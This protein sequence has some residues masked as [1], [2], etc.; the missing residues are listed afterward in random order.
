IRRNPA[1]TLG[2]AAIVQTIYGI[3]GAFIAWGELGAANRLQT[4]L[5]LQPNSAQAAG[6]ALGQFFASFLPYLFLTFGLIFVFEAV[7]TGML[8][9]ALGRGLLGDKITMGEAW[10]LARVGPVLGVT[11]LVALIVLGIYLPVALIVVAL[12]AAHLVG[13][14]IFI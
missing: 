5:N 9:G 10:R 1:A 3:C 11:G 14:A 13:F 2:I 4:T 6:H 8:T 12:I 7:L